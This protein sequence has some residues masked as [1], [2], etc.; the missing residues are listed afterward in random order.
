MHFAQ[1]NVKLTTMTTTFFD[2]RIAGNR[3]EDAFYDVDI[4]ANIVLFSMILRNNVFIKKLS[5]YSR[6]VIQIAS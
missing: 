5:V 2:E 4:A 1:Y 3:L 6:H